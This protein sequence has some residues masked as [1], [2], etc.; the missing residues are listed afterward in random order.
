MTG[1]KNPVLNGTSLDN[2]GTNNTNGNN[3]TNNNQI[4]HIKDQIDNFNKLL[5]NW[6]HNYTLCSAKKNCL[7]MTQTDAS[8]NALDSDRNNLI[9]IASQI[10]NNIDKYN[11]TTDDHNQ[12]QQ[13]KQHMYS[14][15]KELQQIDLE[16]EIA[17]SYNLAGSYQDVK[18]LHT[19]TQFH[20]LVNGL[21][22]LTIICIG[23]YFYFYKSDGLFSTAIA[24][25]LIII[26]IYVICKYIYDHYINV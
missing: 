20:Y 7:K 6:E 15:M 5:Q 17:K 14:V 11:N 4:L 16:D 19:S 22:L 24:L 13:T 10:I 12:N 1:G 26:I 2:N 18:T 21:V 25:I 8:L 23:L 3:D 9:N